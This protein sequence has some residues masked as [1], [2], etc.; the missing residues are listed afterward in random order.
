MVNIGDSLSMNRV[1]QKDQGGPECTTVREELREQKEDEEADTTMEH[2]VQQVHR[3][4]QKA[5]S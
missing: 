4:R 3:P 5:K 1:K 2:D